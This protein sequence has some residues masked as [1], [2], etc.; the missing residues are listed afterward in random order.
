MPSGRATA[1]AIAERRAGE[2]ELLER[3]LREE[4]GVVAD[5]ADRVDERVRVGGV[6]KI[7]RRPRRPRGERR[8]RSATSAASQTSASATASTPAE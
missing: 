2:L 4:A 8:R 1:S 7:M 5:E 3:L 6:A